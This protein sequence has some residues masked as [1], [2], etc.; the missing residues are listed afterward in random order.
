MKAI[1]YTI[2]TWVIFSSCHSTKNFLSKKDEDKALQDAVRA[3]NKKRGNKEAEAAIPV[4]YATIQQKY[5]AAI[6]S[7]NGNANINRYDK[8]AASYNSLQKAY[9]AIAESPFAY[10]LIKPVNYSNEINVLNN[11]AAEAYYNEGASYL[12][13]SGRE[14]AK[15]AYNY[16][17]KANQWV[18]NYRDVKSKMN[19]AYANAVVNVVINPVTTNG[20]FYNTGWNNNNRNYSGQ[21]FQQTLIRDLG[22]SYSSRYPAR[23]YSDW[24]ANSGRLQM[25]WVIDLALHDIDIPRPYETISNRTVSK[26]IETGRDTANRPIYKIVTARITTTKK[27]FTARA[28]M[29]VSIYDANTRRNI[30]YNSFIEDYCWQDE[31]ASYTGDKDAL[32]SDDWRQINNGKRNYEPSRDEVM[33]ELYEK[34]YPRVKNEIA[35]RVNW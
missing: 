8:I 31:E 12:T 19:E 26:Q 10:D 22:G 20:Y 9:N 24:E 23:F 29:D 2:I 11:N 15:Q 34:L 18:S 16:F 13:L 25:D 33:N 32:S 30:G 27:S 17:N 28:K 3:I 5:L 21:N 14:N 35:C 4:L 1:F 6:A 7:Q